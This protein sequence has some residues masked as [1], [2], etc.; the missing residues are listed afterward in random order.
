MADLDT[1]ALDLARRRELVVQ[2]GRKGMSLPEIAAHCGVNERT[3][4]RDRE[5]LGLAGPLRVPLSREEHERI[6]E[7]LADGVSAAEIGR[8]IGRSYKTILA[9][10]P[11]RSTWRGNLLRDVFFLRQQLG[12]I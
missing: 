8:T 12:L 2:L 5:K 10:Y 4:N 9:H 6:Q 11:G 3:I 1:L 7:M